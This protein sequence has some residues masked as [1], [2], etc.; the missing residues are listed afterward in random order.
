MWIRAL[1]IGERVGE[2]GAVRGGGAGEGRERTSWRT[3]SRQS[4]ILTKTLLLTKL[5]VALNNES[6]SEYSG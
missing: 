6:R 1:E 2:R 3:R 4:N 5:C